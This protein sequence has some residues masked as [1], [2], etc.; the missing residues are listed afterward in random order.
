MKNNFKYTIY[1]SY[2]GYVVQ[3]IIN[4]FT[5]LLFL[6]FQ[7]NFS[8]TYNQISVLILLNFLFQL[9][10]DMLSSGVIKKF[11]YRACIVTAHVLAAVG[12]VSLAVLP[13]VMPN[14]F[15]GVIIS[16]LLYATGSGLIEVIVSPLVEACPTENKSASMSLL[17]S[18]YCWGQMS[19]IL[20]STL[21]FLISS[22]EN[23]RILSVIWAVVP[24]C[25]AVNFCL[26]P[27]PSILDGENGDSLKTLSKNK[28]FLLCSILMFCAGASELSMS[29]WASAFA[30]SGLHVS[31]TA[32]DLLGPCL[33]A[34]LMGSSR[35]LY[36]K[37]SKKVSIKKAMFVSA[38]LC[39]V[40]YLVASLSPIPIISLIFCGICG[41]SVGIMWPGTF[42]LGAANI[43]TGGTLMFA[44]FAMFGDL[45]CSTG[46]FVVGQLTSLFSDDLGKGL[47][48]AAVF[49][50]ILAVTV[51]TMKEKKSDLQQ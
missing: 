4:N 18:F 38:C 15:V 20:L 30:E 21:F 33:F 1:A 43:P 10:V 40:S 27:I 36:A 7:K 8:F 14:P 34:F 49:P 32:G 22:V 39:V 47:L 42:S 17:H 29:Q 24:I 26:V 19:V 41:F 3:A 48:F 5:P 2:A 12:L 6:T 31:K 37:I 51:L 35:V 28:L 50:L 44:L 16:I 45:G 13:F 9:I 46:P 23:W 25:N 11:G